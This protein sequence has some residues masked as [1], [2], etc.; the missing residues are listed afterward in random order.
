MAALLPV[1]AVV[2]ATGR[3]STDPAEAMEPA[4]SIV[5][6]LT[7]DQRVDS[8]QYMP[9]VRRTLVNRGVKFTNAYV[10]NPVCCPARSTILTGLYSHTTGVYTNDLNGGFAKFDDSSTIATWL[11]DDGY[12]TGLFGK[13]LNGYENNEY[14]PPGWDRW[15]ATYGSGDY[16]DY[17]ATMDGAIVQYGHD[18]AD[19]G[20]S[21]VGNQTTSFIRETPSDQPLFAYVSLPAPHVPSTP[22]PGDDEAFR[23]LEPWRPPSYNERNVQDKP[24]YIRSHPRLKQGRRL[25]IDYARAQQLR[26]LPEVDRVVGDIVDALRETGRLRN[27]MIVFTSDNGLLWGEHRRASKDVPYEESIAVPLVVRYDAVI[28]EARTDRSLV[29]NVDF[30]PTFV[31][32]AGAATQPTEGMSLMPLLLDPATPWRSGFL[33]EH[34]AA[35]GGDGVPS[36]CGY[37]TR[38]Y[39]LIRYNGESEL[40]DLKADPWQQFNRYGSSSYQRVQDSLN[41]RLLAA[42]VPRPPR[43]TL[44]DSPR[45]AVPDTHDGPIACRAVRAAVG[46]EHRVTLGAVS[47]STLTEHAAHNPEPSH[48][49]P[50]GG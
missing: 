34:Q 6:I 1:P 14:I 29:T 2:G 43:L 13:Y 22:A 23:D 4:P 42:C 10:V 32:A 48:D 49:V 25:Q 46:S 26:T 41:D 30:A 18:Q 16:Y 36:Y 35:H 20:T 40:Y 21:V 31:D 27:S 45:S 3:S 44:A 50:S 9:I 19:Y 28:Q 15:F 8:L 39:V 37:H 12:R 17:S 47:G 5:L 7:D 38:R 24:R 33:I 11:H